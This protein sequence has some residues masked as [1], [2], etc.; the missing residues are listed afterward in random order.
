MTISTNVFL[1]TA[2]VTLVG[3]GATTIAT[4]LLSG[5]IEFLLGIVAFYVYEKFPASP[6][7]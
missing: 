2:A 3:L 7:N 5:S 4:N 6:T 1:L